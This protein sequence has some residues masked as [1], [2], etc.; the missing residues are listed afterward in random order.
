MLLV[1]LK[2]ALVKFN[3]LSKPGIFR[4]PGDKVKAK[5]L[6]QRLNMKHKL[7]TSSDDIHSIALVLKVIHAS[8]S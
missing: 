3:G 5:R 6:R 8:I 2:D 4:L 1:T 7:N